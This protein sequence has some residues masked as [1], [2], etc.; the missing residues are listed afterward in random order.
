MVKNTFGTKV[1]MTNYK[2]TGYYFQSNEKIYFIQFGEK[3]ISIFLNG[4]VI[5]NIHTGLIS[6]M[7]QATQK[8]KQ[9][10]DEIMSII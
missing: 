10:I 3:V 7:K 2:N 4:N 1:A 9:I 8:A 5:K 6:D